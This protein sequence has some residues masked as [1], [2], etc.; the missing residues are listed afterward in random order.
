MSKRPSVASLQA[1]IANLRPFQELSFCLLRG[2]K[3]VPLQSG[4][5]RVE[6]IGAGRASGGIAIVGGSSVHFACDY[7]QRL[8]A[9]ADPYLRDLASQIRRLQREALEK[10]EKGTGERSVSCHCCGAT[11]RTDKP[12]DPQRDSGFGTCL[13][14]HSTVAE[15][16][17]KHG[18][19]GVTVLAEAL[20]RL[21]KYA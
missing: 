13:N 3:R 5:L 20:E 16:W 14:C 4:D 17:A 11:F 10:R 19:P 1:E 18:F 2:S 12:H 7:A 9:T 6:I 21:A 15:S 8:E